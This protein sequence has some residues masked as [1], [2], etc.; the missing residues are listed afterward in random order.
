MMSVPPSLLSYALKCA[1]S[2]LSRQAQHLG[3][4]LNATRERYVR[5]ASGVEDVGKMWW[6]AQAAQESALLCVT[7]ESSKET[8]HLAYEG[9]FDFLL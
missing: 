6:L 7:A 2:A 4:I 8:P 9:G 3:R 5:L 1:P